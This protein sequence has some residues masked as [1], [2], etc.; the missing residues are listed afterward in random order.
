MYCVNNASATTT[1]AS[2]T[3]FVNKMNVRCLSCFEIKI[4]YKNARAFRICIRGEDKAKFLDMINWP[5]GIVIRDWVFK[6]TVQVA[7]AA[8]LIGPLHRPTSRSSVNVND[9][10]VGLGDAFVLIESAVSAMSSPSRSFLDKGSD[11]A[12]EG[13]K[14]TQ[15][16]IKLIH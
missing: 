11:I 3:D 13:T 12:C 9:E 10:P 1:C 8:A 6:D 14:S 2:V 15:S 7:T 16:D 5:T 4:R